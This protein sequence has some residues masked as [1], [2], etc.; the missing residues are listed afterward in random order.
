MLMLSY[1]AL[2][3]GDSVGLMCFSDRIHSFVPPRGGSR[4]MNHLLNASYDR[5]PDLVESRYGEAFMHL[6]KHCRK[7]SLVILVTNVIDEINASQVHQYLSTMV[8][9]HL[10]MGVLLRDHELFRCADTNWRDDAG[11]YRTAA[12]A[13]IIC[14]RHEVIKD[15]QHEGVLSLDVFPESMTAPMINRYLEVKARHLL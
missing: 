3:R 13:E 2:K 6:S 10:P 14:W 11:M 1:I 4:Q 12:A 5:F 9:R 7:R 8:G 15:L